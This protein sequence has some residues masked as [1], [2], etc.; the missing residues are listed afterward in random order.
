MCTRLP[1]LLALIIFVV[2]TPLPVRADTYVIPFSEIREAVDTSGE[3]PDVVIRAHLAGLIRDELDAM[4]FDVNGGLLLNDVPVEEM[5]RIIETDCD[6]PRPYEVHT[7]A[8]TARVIIDDGSSLTLNLDSLQAISLVADL[9]G[10]VSTAADA[11]VRWGQDIPF[12]G[13]DCEKID[14]DHGW[15]ALTVPFDIGLELALEL[16][17]AYDSGLLA[18]VV[19]KQALLQGQATLTGGRLQH[20]FGSISLTDLLIDIF[21]DELL[22][23]LQEKGEQAVT[24]AIAALN[25]RLDGLDENGIPDPTLTVFN[26]PTTFILDVNEE[27][28]A[29]V[30]ELLE[31]YG[32][33]EIVITMLDDRAIEVL[34]QLTILEGAEREAYLAELG[35]SFSCD[36]LLAAFRTPLDTV[37]LYT[38]NG[39]LCEAANLAGPDASDYF[40]DALCTE[41]VAY[42]GTDNADFCQA[43]VGD[44]AASRLGNAASWVAEDNQA[45]DPLPA[46]P[47]RPWTT[48]PSTE[49]DLGVL[50]LQGN[51]QPFMKQLRYKTVANVA[52]GS[53]TCELEMR[54]YKNDISADGLK[55]VIAL[56]GGTWRHRGTS[57]LGLE[58]GISHLTERGFVVFAPFYRLTGEDDGNA[59]CNAVTW[60][61]VTAD[62][63]SALDWVR[64]NGAA[65]GAESGPVSVFGQSAGAQLAGW[66]AA[67]RPDD[68]RKAIMNYGPTDVLGFLQ[69]AVPFGGP[70][71]AFRDFGLNSISRFFGAPG[72]S[73]EL[74]LEHIGF[75]GLTIALLQ[76]EWATL[77]P[78]T[79]FDL[80]RLDPMAPPLYVERCADATQTDL[81]AINLPMPPAELTECLKQDLRD[82]LIENSLAHQLS[83]EAAPFHA[84]HGSADALVPY[85]QSLA[86]C[87][88]VNNSVLPTDVTAPLT[89]HAC[90]E[91][92]EVQIVRDADHAF[93]LGVC[94]D[95]I[96]PA[97]DSGSV[98]RDAVVSAIE[99]SYA[100]LQEDP[101]VPAPPPPVTVNPPGAPAVTAPAS[102][103]SSGGGGCS[104]RS[105]ESGPMQAGAWWLLLVMLALSRLRIH[106]IRTARR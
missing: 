98:T 65:F 19:D 105:Q 83:D 87:D 46:V 42:R 96:C 48:V 67:H 106:N 68:V 97:G 16:N 14:T 21:E 32:I 9:T 64:D 71:E 79:V 92:S 103:S 5:T 59:E 38:L 20:D 31:Q 10:T 73:D 8:T 99:S 11:W 78:D 102:G 58:A 15:V 24:D 80:S 22:A 47:S 26:A 91:N 88:A 2:A 1:F 12:F 49:L 13:D 23:T 4:G 62:A 33:P 55:P 69:G 6:F 51:R 28:Q 37:P 43:Y 25:Y 53:G 17:P 35:A 74:H 27:D 86:L 54:V 77:I 30:R 101:S 52:R 36:V 93:E 89:K 94:I 90:G 82:F 66:L 76:D 72:G 84:V 57:F 45:N 75:A 34:L 56:H 7:D 50:P 61:E 100:W 39:H 60:R 63:E 44:Q 29:S 40:V 104:L 3:S 85:E 18:I 70:Y 41:A 95:A 81:G